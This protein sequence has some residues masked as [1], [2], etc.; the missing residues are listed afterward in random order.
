[1]NGQVDAKRGNIGDTAVLIIAKLYCCN[2]EGE[3]R[4]GKSG[5]QN[6]QTRHPQSCITV[7]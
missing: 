5:T 3:F 7:R 6:K 4:N 1:M 2:F